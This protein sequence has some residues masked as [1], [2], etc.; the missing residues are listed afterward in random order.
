M[1]LNNNKTLDLNFKAVQDPENENQTIKADVK[2][3]TGFEPIEGLV[4]R[5]KAKNYKVSALISTY[6]SERFLRGC[7]EDLSRQTIFSETELIIINSGSPEN[8]DAIVRDFLKQY[9]NITYLHTSREPLYAAWNRGIKIAQAPYIT[10]AN[11]DD[12]HRID[13]LEILARNL[14]NNPECGI[15]YANVYR[16]EK[17]NVPFEK[18]EVKGFH[19][20]QP[21][22]HVNLLRKC[23]V[24]PQ[25][26]WRASVHQKVGY[27]SEDYP[28]VGDHEFWLRVSEE[29]PLVHVNEMLGC[30]LEHDGQLQASN[31]EGR[32]YDNVEVKIQYLEKYMKRAFTSKDQELFNKHQ[33]L[34]QS[35]ISILK[36]QG[37]IADWNSF[38]NNFYTLA[39][40]AYKN[41]DLRTSLTMCY[42]YLAMV[43]QAKNIVILYRWLLS[44][45]LPPTK[46]LDKKPLVSV[47][48]PLYNLGHYLWETV[49]SVVR[50]NYSNWEL[51]IVDDGSSDDSFRVAYEVKEKFKE[52]AIKLVIQKNSG[53]GA[54]RNRGLKEAVGEYLLIL[55]ADD[56]LASN[57]LEEAVYLLNTQPDISW[58]IPKTLQFGPNNNKL[59]WTWEYSF[60]DSFLKCPTP[61]SSV[62]R[63]N[64]FEAL[65][66]FDENMTDRED[67]DFWIRAGE[68]GFMGKTTSDVGFLY[69]KAI[70]RFGERDDINFQSKIE[71]Y[72]RHQWIY[73]ELSES[74][75]QKVFNQNKIGAFPPEILNIE[76][77][78]KIN[79]LGINGKEVKKQIDFIK[80]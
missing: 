22:S 76:L 79:S 2:E 42:D 38:E 64:I 59:W 44:K 35:E 75:K 60:V 34:L 8:E 70:E 48:I 80:N 36:A 46:L 3:S 68:E 19:K 66:G 58:V 7:L 77:A 14:D 49:E 9:D 18:I 28:I 52:Y 4:T 54:C 74:D 15:S 57:Y 51:I 61:V 65:N 25:P 27:F 23:E 78:Q 71:I 29:F 43:G 47:V 55:D 32:Y 21:Y 17:E 73:R 11:T 1:R 30:F 24:G 6:A 72:D 69:R 16:V 39:L 20:W 40:L 5:A 26:M 45:P 13:C 63:K 33:K 31:D 37:S 62:F 10:N 53:K 41:G 56:E 12:K 67:W 50:Q